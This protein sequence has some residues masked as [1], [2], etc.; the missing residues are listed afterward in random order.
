MAHDGIQ[1]Q[2]FR[3]RLK[4]QSQGSEGSRKFVVEYRLEIG[5]RDFT[6]LYA[7]IIYHDVVRVIC[8]LCLRVLL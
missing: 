4:L 3:N 6:S 1:H 5:I 2:R 7:P 8:A